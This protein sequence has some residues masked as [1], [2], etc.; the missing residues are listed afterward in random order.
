MAEENWTFETLHAHLCLKITAV[1][2]VVNQRFKGSD[3]VHRKELR[4][5]TKLVE[6]RDNMRQEAI[7]TAFQRSSE[8]LAEAK[9]ASLLGFQKSNEWQSTFRELSSTYLPRTEY[10]TDHQ[11]LTEKL[12]LLVSRLDL[13]Q[14]ARPVAE[15]GN[16]R[17]ILTVVALVVSIAAVIAISLHR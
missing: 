11:N 15:R 8:A 4:S 14:G 17:D 3:K 5:L 16:W 7:G 10:N 2:K 6:Q 12:N 1:E 13:Y 9:A